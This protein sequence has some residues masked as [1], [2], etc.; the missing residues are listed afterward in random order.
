MSPLLALMLS[1][2]IA[3]P[4]DHPAPQPEDR[5]IVLSEFQVWADA[6]GPEVFK[7]LSDMYNR[8]GYSHVFRLY[9]HYEYYV[10]DAKRMRGW[11]DEA[12]E[13]GAFNVFCIGDDT[14]TAQGHLL[15]DAGL[16]PDLAG[17]Y[18]EIVE[19][20][21][22]KGFMVAVEP[23]GLP[24]PRDQERFEAWLRTW[25]GPDVPK[26]RRADIIKLSLEW[27]QAYGYNPAIADEVEAFMEAAKV[28]CPDVLVYI[29]SIGNIWKTPQPFHS[30]LLGQYPGTIVSHYLGTEQVEAFRAMGARN[31]MV[32]INP[33]ELEKGAGQFFIYHDQ[34]VRFLKDI[35]KARVPYVSL[36]GVNF[37]YNRYNYDLFLDIL[38]PHLALA[39]DL[40]FLRATIVPDEIAD[41]ATKEE[42]AARCLELRAARD[43]EKDPPV[44]A[45]AAGAPAFF[46]ECPDATRSVRFL[47]GLGDGAIAPRLEGP[48]T[49]P[50]S[51]RPAAATFGLDFGERRTISKLTVTP[52]LHPDE[53]VYV[54]TDF[55]LE[56]RV[57]G[58]WR[59][60]P[61][62][63][64][65]GNALRVF[66][67]EFDPV[68]ADAVRIVIA[69]ETDDGHGNYRACCQELNAS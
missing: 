44:P 33:C 65:T 17:A 48:M 36:A 10:W 1:L 69:S 63:E 18:N 2:A 21:H 6:S 58:E 11:V 39:K 37:G 40:D 9:P 64:V 62:G 67:L 16:N 60:L 4:A 55:R 61:G 47:A 45:N 52:C 5:F 50:P 38:R 24:A 43:A 41:P 25:V 59:T 68:T 19:Y 7:E 42:V 3:Q 51:A 31:M 34:T 28:V 35:V 46:A 22:E 13:L 8:I 54:A 49:D 29:D 23:H 12:V 20:A 26:E 27:F 56:Y 14:R 32:Q 66:A 30:W 57:D 15:T 53:D